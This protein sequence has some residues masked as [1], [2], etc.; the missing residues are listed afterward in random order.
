MNVHTYICMVR[1]ISIIF[2]LIYLFSICYY[3]FCNISNDESQN[4]AFDFDN[5]NYV[6]K[7]MSK[8]ESWKNP[9]SGWDHFWLI[10]SCPNK[11]IIYE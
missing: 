5:I 6:A 10:I 11:E 7:E 1:F 9:A 2:Q 8:Y 4:V 3:T